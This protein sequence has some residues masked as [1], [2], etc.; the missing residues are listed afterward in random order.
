MTFLYIDLP[1]GITSQPVCHYNLVWNMDTTHQSH[2][3]NSDLW[4]GRNGNE[5]QDTS[6]LKVQLHR[7][8]WSKSS[9]PGEFWWIVGHKNSSGISRSPSSWHWTKPPFLQSKQR[10][11]HKSTHQKWDKKNSPHHSNVHPG[12]C[13]KSRLQTGWCFLEISMNLS[14]EKWRCWISER[15]LVWFLLV[16]LLEKV[17]LDPWCP[18]S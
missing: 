15:V 3:V 10:L 9:H 7:A 6:I 12:I 4:M 11:I 16:Q 1:F 13:H 14:Q 5:L 8:W 17:F 18:K 2:Q